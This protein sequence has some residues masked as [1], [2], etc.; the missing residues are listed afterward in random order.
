MVAYSAILASVRSISRMSLCMASDPRCRARVSR[1]DVLPFGFQAGPEQLPLDRVDASGAFGILEGL[2]AERGTI[3][4]IVHHPQARLG[5][6][7]SI[8]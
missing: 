2:R 1:N 3:A 6:K 5:R 7:A 8:G 4:I